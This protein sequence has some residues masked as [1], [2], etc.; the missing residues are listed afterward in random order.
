MDYLIEPHD[1]LPDCD[2]GDCARHERNRLR[3]A[4]WHPIETAPTD[5]TAILVAHCAG[6]WVAKYRETYASGYKPENPWQSMML[7]HEHF[8]YRNAPHRPTHWRPLPAAPI[9]LK[10]PKFANVFCSQCGQEFGPGDHGFSHCENHKTKMPNVMCT[11][12]GV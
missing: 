5:G 8:D 4:A 2:C 6:V 1:P 7:N 9:G 3:D 10:A 12:N 11:P